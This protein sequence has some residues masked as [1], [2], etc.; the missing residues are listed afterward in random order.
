[1]HM[2][3]EALHYLKVLTV[4]QKALQIG[5]VSH[6][7]ETVVDRAPK[8]LVHFSICYHPSGKPMRVLLLLELYQKHLK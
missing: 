3:N 7:E 5:C 2:V 1:M 8:K 6:F 4:V